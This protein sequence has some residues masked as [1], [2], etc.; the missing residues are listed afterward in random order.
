MRAC[1]EFGVSCSESMSLFSH[2]L[3]VG[4]YRDSTA[5]SVTRKKY[6]LVS[7]GNGQLSTRT[8]VILLWATTRLAP[9]ITHT[10]I[11]MVYVLF[12]R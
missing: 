7:R 9:D 1:Y 3:M 2:Y 4:N 10:I 8:P 12:I 6:R 11:Y 5:Y